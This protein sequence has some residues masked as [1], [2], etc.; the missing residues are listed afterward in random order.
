M[1]WWRICSVDGADPPSI[2]ER[3]MLRFISESEEAA[4][5]A[6]FFIIG[7]GGVAGDVV[8]TRYLD[9]LRANVLDKEHWEE[10]LRR[11]LPQED[12]SFLGYWELY[13]RQGDQ[14]V[15]LAKAEEG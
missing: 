1:R 13:E 7:T 2:E 3:A 10:E 11:V 6:Q 5:H 14:I 15:L 9:A 12:H 4:K 8:K